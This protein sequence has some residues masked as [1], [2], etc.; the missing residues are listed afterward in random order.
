MK[1]KI[2]FSLIAFIFIAMLVYTKVYTGRVIDA[3]TKEPIK[4]AVV[5][6]SWIEERADIAGPTSKS[7]NVK[8]T[9][10]NK[11]GRWMIWG[12]RG[13]E[14]GTITS[15]FTFL[16]FTYIT[17]PPEFIVFK[18]GYCSWPEG[19]MIKACKMK[20]SGVGNGGIIELL[21]LTDREDRLRNSSLWP[22]LMDSDNESLKKIKNLLKLL[23][24]EDR[25]LGL[26]GD[27][28][29]KELENEK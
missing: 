5:V 4:G 15:I 14:M 27:P 11:N 24:Q 29:L 25:N 10:T 16:T 3:G 6:A 21:K 7:K 19:F 18:P 13:M 17:N 23:D 8:E 20:P 28:R 26:S 12:P 1:R 2:I 22:S 9:L